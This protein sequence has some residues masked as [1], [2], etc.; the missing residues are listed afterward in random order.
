MINNEDFETYLYISNDKFTISVFS[1]LNFKLLY[2]EKFIFENNKN[3]FYENSLIK[4]LDNN[5]FKIEKKF[6]NFIDNL[7]LIIDNE[8]FISIDISIKKNLYG[9]FPSKNNQLNLLSDL[10]NEL[11]KNYADQSII[12]LIINSFLVDGSIVKNIDYNLKCQNF[13]IELTFICLSK[14]EI[15]YYQKI[16]KKYQISINKI[17]NGKYIKRFFLDQNLDECEMGLK[18]VLGENPNEIFFHTKSQKNQGFF[19]KFFRL[20][21]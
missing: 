15:V 2:K 17:I 8:N 4:F 7:N 9:D 13:C 3:E 6:N 12:H 19:E 11:K 16:L 20:F 5:I 14:N 18:I 21:S 1:K 10:R